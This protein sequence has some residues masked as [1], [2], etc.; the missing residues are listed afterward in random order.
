[1]I[2]LSTWKNSKYPTKTAM[3][4]RTDDDRIQ[5]FIDYPLG[6]TLESFIEYEKL[7]WSEGWRKT[8]Q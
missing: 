7:L 5:I 6:L 1:M 2:T 8:P 3:I 4:Q